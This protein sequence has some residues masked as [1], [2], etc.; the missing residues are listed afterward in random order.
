M[1]ERAKALVR[2]RP[3]EVLLAR[4]LALLLLKRGVSDMLQRDYRSA[5]EHL[6]DARR[7]LEKHIEDG[8]ENVDPAL[9]RTLHDVLRQEARNLRW[10]ADSAAALR[11][12]ARA[13]D[14]AS[15]RKDELDTLLITQAVER[16]R[17]LRRWRATMEE[18]AS[19]FSDLELLC[20]VE[21][22]EDGAQPWRGNIAPVVS[23]LTN[24]S[25]MP[26]LVLPVG[27]WVLLERVQSWT[28]TRSQ[29]RHAAEFA[30]LH[31]ILANYSG[32]DILGLRAGEW[33]SQRIGAKLS[34]GERRGYEPFAARAEQTLER[35][36]AEGDID[37]LERIPELYPF[38]D[39]AARSN[40][41][42]LE[43]SLASGDVEVVADIVLSDLPLNWNVKTA[44]ERDLLHLVRLAEV[45]GDEGNLELRA[46]LAASLARHAP[47]LKPAVGGD[48]TRSLADIAKDWELAPLPE[49]AATKARFGREPKVVRPFA[50]SFRFLGEIPP[51][52]GEEAQDH[53]ILFADRMRLFAFADRE[54]H[55]LAEPVWREFLSVQD[56]FEDEPEERT[57]FSRGRVHVA[58]ARRIMT[59]D[60]ATGEELWSW[61]SRSKGLVRLTAS[62]GVVVAVERT[63]GGNARTGPHRLIGLDAVSGIEL[64]RLNFDTGLKYWLY[65][66]LGEGRMVLIPRG[67]TRDY[68]QVFDL[69]TGRLATSF[70]TGPHS[71]YN[72]RAAW[73]Q[74]ERVVLPQFRRSTRPPL[75]YVEAFDLEDGDDA[76][77]I[78]FNDF[79]GG[80]RELD[81]SRTPRR[82]SLPTPAFGLECGRG[83]GRVRT[84]RQVGRARLDAED[85]ARRRRPRRRAARQSP[86][87]L[88]R[89]AHV[90][91]GGVR[92]R[93]LVHVEGL[94]P[95]RRRL[96]P[97][98]GEPPPLVHA[99]ERGRDAAPSRLG[100]R[101]G[102]RLPP[103]G[104]PQ[105][106]AQDRAGILRSRHGRAHRHAHVAEGHEQDLGTRA[107]RNARG[108]PDRQWR[109]AD[110]FHA[111][112]KQHTRPAAPLRRAG[113]ATCLTLAS[114]V[115]APS[116]HGQRGRS[117]DAG[118]LVKITAE[119]EEAVDRGLQ[120]LKNHQ[121]PDG[122]WTAKIGFKLNSSY[123]YTAEGKGH[124][125]V[126]ALAGM[127]FLAGGHLPGR[128]KYG[129]VV[130]NCLR[131][132]LSCVQDDGY[133][134]YQGTRMYSHAFATLFLA[135]IYGM[136]HRE[137]VRTKLQKAVDFIV[138]CQ[139]DAGGWRYVPLA[140]ESDMSIVVCQALALRA[141]RNIGIRVPK[142]T[143]DRAIKYVVDS[144]VTSSSRSYPGS[145]FRNDPGTFHYQPD[146]HSRTTF[147]LT[148]AGVTALHGLGVYS[149]KLIGKG[150]EFLNQDFDKFNSRWGR[151][152]H[153]F[154]W[155]GHY[156][157]VQAMYSQGGQRLEANY[158][159]QAA[160]AS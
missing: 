99:H 115:A 32:V 140:R 64:W 57:A 15:T 132:V 105:A 67:Q 70:R 1:V 98:A 104:Q 86:G 2:E 144:A 151:R 88:A 58:S 52:A 155:Y 7:A 24:E 44:T 72:V 127:A 68:A 124:V 47:H 100:E 19:G 11:R 117:D 23:Q 43:L 143:I 101:G 158:F 69:F 74:E 128:G 59:L 31:A 39:A 42:R 21:R 10:R 150:I 46:G 62:D 45:L 111:M 79:R 142:S 118:P 92:R 8:D 135:E 129:D 77:R 136:T 35:A 125:G 138:K 107:L 159:D 147:P 114:L 148:A 41:K 109:P 87:R 22:D 76:W 75:N 156:Y 103:A 34:K 85:R 96:E 4:D 30:D 82:H 145:A 113:L 160:R 119:Q 48:A 123:R 60:R 27:L 33:A 106:R 152:G 40:D 37:L 61:S 153:Y 18:I 90:R 80:R 137:D 116:A 139:N 28:G 94:R 63:A 93:R 121:N 97:L 108:R 12:L 84:Q 120:W 65:P 3:E 130:D 54:G 6:T 133:I 112:K 146:N 91:L 17:D 157:G 14:L 154:F 50:G 122:S 25:S 149:N 9:R 83:D 5:S 49:P 126:T 66:I 55:E 16:S 36:L 131:F 110:G 89:A 26:K 78:E 13:R 56:D 73:I 51:A 95:A 71:L 20:E 102:R 141:A 134:T 29:E 38:S 53:V 81:A